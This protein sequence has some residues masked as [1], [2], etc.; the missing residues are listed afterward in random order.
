MGLSEGARLHHSKDAPGRGLARPDLRS[1]EIST[2][3][4]GEFTNLKILKC[5][6]LETSRLHLANKLN[7][8]NLP[9][10]YQGIIV[11]YLVNISKKRAFWSLNE[12]IL[13]ITILK[14][15]NLYPSRKIWRIHA[16]TH[17]RPQRKEDQYAVFQ[18]SNDDAAV[19]QTRLEDKQLEE[20]TNTTFLV[21]EQAEVHLGIKMGANIMVI[22]VPGQEGAE[23]NVAE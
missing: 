17:Q 16:C 20:K 19:T 5:W 4:G 2:N 23:G 7:M 21:N 12:D 11:E 8:E 14:T 22:G 10:K 15:N 9:S 18:V 3:I 13:K 6:S 1:K